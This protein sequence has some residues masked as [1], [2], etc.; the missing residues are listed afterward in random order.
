MCEK[1]ELENLAIILVD[2]FGKKPKTGIEI[3]KDIVIKIRP[4]FT[5]ALT[6]NSRWV[7]F[8]AFHPLKRGV[9]MF[10]TI[11][12]FF[13]RIED[14]LTYDEIILKLEELILKNV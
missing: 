9:L 3:S 13:P 11:D 5:L 6:G 1:S 8:C 12:T 14:Q 7:Q 2:K 4:H 10:E